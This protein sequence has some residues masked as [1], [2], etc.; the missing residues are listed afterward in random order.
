V[1]CKPPNF[2]KPLSERLQDG[3]KKGLVRIDYWHLETFKLSRSVPTYFSS[4]KCRGV[5]LNFCPFCGFN[6]IEDYIETG[7]I[8]RE[9]ELK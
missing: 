2:C 4:P 9:K 3:G 8:K 6:F 7:W 5:G 1:K